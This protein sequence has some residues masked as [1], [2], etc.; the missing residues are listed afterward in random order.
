M[1]QIDLTRD[2]YLKAERVRRFLGKDGLR[3]ELHG[4]C[5]FN[6]S[7]EEAIEEYNRCSGSNNA[8]VMF[9]CEF[10]GNNFVINADQLSKLTGMDVSLIEQ[11]LAQI[12]ETAENEEILDRIED[13]IIRGG[14]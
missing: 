14:A 8:V 11:K 2:I 5:N 13:E 12:L 6:R 1:K 7:S 9:N 3:M 4:D 10:D